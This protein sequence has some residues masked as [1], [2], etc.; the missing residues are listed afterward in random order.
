MF[1][2]YPNPNEGNFDVTFNASVK[3][4]YRLELHNAL[5]QLVF[6][7]EIVDFT[8]VYSK[9]L[10]VTEYGKGIYTI[11]LKNSKNEIVKRIVV[12]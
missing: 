9:K 10:N 12:N 5:G 7:D 8:G 3:S 1:S 2:V 4:T 11:S 6:K